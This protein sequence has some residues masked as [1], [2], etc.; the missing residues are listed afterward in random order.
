MQTIATIKVPN[1]MLNDYRIIIATRAEVMEG[2]EAAFLNERIGTTEDPKEVVW[3]N[4]DDKQAIREFLSSADR[5]IAGTF[6]EEF[7]PVDPRMRVEHELC[8]CPISGVAAKNV[9]WGSPSEV[10]NL[11]WAFIRGWDAYWGAY[12]FSEDNDSDGLAIIYVED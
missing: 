2:M 7:A 12:D 5:I 1:D 9:S 11:P 6:F 3:L 8:L 4:D 10:T